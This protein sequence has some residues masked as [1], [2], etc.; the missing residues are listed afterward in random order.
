VIPTFRPILVIL[1]ASTLLAG[2]AMASEGMNLL[3]SR[4]GAPLASLTEAEFSLFIEGR[5]LYTTPL[6]PEDGLGPIFN[7]SNCQSCHSTPVGGWG[8]I[9]VTHFGFEDKDVFEDLESLGGPLLQTQTTS[10][11]CG[12]FVPGEANVVIVR[13]TNSSLAFGMIE[14]IPDAAI[15]ANED[16]QPTA[17]ASPAASTGC[18]P[19]RRRPR[20]RF[21]PDA[22]AGRRRSRRCS[23]S[24]RTP[25]GT[26][27]A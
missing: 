18:V 12:E 24:R 15:A 27:W 17:T 13:V 6:A 4:A 21:A 8:N 20:A 19:S 2:S 11:G 7:K 25:R 22:S 16:P 9:A 3:Q 14:A 1:G 26:R 23:P 10:V 5:A